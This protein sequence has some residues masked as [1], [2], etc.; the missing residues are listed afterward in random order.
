MP[1]PRFTERITRTLAEAGDDQARSDYVF[2]PFT[3]TSSFLAPR[4]ALTTAKVISRR[5]FSTPLSEG[6]AEQTDEVT[7]GAEGPRT[8]WRP[9]GRSLRCSVRTCMQEV[10]T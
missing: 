4:C 6:C 2:K 7:P 1:L 10:H 5:P 8:S 9:A 3:H